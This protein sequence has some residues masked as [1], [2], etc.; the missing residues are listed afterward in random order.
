MS[1]R[2][3]FVRVE[4]A[5][6]DPMDDPANAKLVCEAIDAALLATGF[7]VVLF[8]TRECR[9]PTAAVRE[10]YWSWTKAGAHHD[11]VAILAQSEMTRVSGNMTALALE[12]PLRSFG[13][14]AEAVKW[15]LR[16][17]PSTAGA[18]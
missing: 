4:H 17:R 9:P 13:D 18:S 7:R 3:G 10:V 14:E 11:R 6:D 16:K 2:D 1:I 8:E 5:A 12:A 15:L